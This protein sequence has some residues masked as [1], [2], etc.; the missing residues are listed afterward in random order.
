MFGPPAAAGPLSRTLADTSGHEVAAATTTNET[1][2]RGQ[3]TGVPHGLQLNQA[4]GQ[5]RPRWLISAPTTPA[6]RAEDTGSPADLLSSLH[7]DPRWD[8][9]SRAYE[10]TLGLALAADPAVLDTARAAVRAVHRHQQRRGTVDPS[11]AAAVLFPES[12]MPSDPL[13]ALE[14]LL[15]PATDVTLSRLMDM[16]ARGTGLTDWFA[17]D[18]PR[19]RDE[20]GNHRRD[21]RD[22]GLPLGDGPAHTAQK[23]LTRYRMLPGTRREDSA[24]FREVVLGWLLPTGRHSLT[25]IL[26]ASHAAGLGDAA[27]RAVV[28]G[29]AAH[30]YAWAERTLRPAGRPGAQDPAA[31]RPPHRALYATDAARIGAEA[32]GT[33]ML[34][35]G[36]AGAIRRGERILAADPDADPDGLLEREQALLERLR[37]HGGSAL[38]GLDES[39]LTALYLLGG[40]DAALLGGV[41]VVPAARAAL[42]A[43]LEGRGDFPVL[44][45]EVPEFRSLV[46]EARAL[47]AADRAARLATSAVLLA[48]VVARSADLLRTRADQH[49]AVALEALSLLPPVDTAVWWGSWLPGEAPA[50]QEAADALPGVVTVARLHPVRLSPSAA[51]RALADASR[52]GHHPVLYEVERS[53][54]RDISPY[55]A[56]PE[57]RR[58]AHA[59]P[60]EFDVTARVPRTDP[61]TGLRYTLVRLA[62]RPAVLPEAPA[63]RTAAPHY[64]EPDYWN[65]PWAGQRTVTSPSEIAAQEIRTAD[66]RLVGRASFTAADWSLRAPFYSGLRDTAGY[67]EWSR[68]PGGIRVARQRALPATGSGGTFFWTS[69]GGTD[70]FTVAGPD[71]LPSGATGDTVGRLLGT[72]PRDAGFTSVTVVV[73]EPVRGDGAPADPADT[74]RRVQGIADATGLDVFVNTGRV[75]V[76]PM[77]R[78]DGSPAAAV[79]L[80]ENADG[81][82][83]GWL[84]VSP[85]FRAAPPLPAPP[86]ERVAPAGPT[87]QAVLPGNPWSVSRWRIPGEPDSLRFGPL[88]ARRDWRTLSYQYEV[89]LARHIAARPQTRAVLVDA[90]SRLHARL[91]AQHGPHGADLALGLAAPGQPA[92]AGQAGPSPALARF[93]E[94][95]PTVGQ[96]M[97]AFSSAAYGPAPTS[98]RNSEPGRIG[99]PHPPH[100]R[101]HRQGAYRLAHDDRGFRYVGGT[102]GPA[103][104]LLQAYRATGADAQRMVAFRSAVLAW[105]VLTDNQSLAEV[106][107][108]SHLAG[109]GTDEE[110]VAL[111]RDGARLHLWARRSLAPD[112]PLPLPHHAA[113]DATTRFRSSY[114]LEIPG[115]IATALNAA[116]T[117]TKVPEKSEELT[118][119][120]E[121]ARK[122]LERFGE[123]GRR[124][125]T[126]LAPG[127]LTALFRYTGSD[128]KLFKTFVTAS[129]LG[130]AGVRWLMRH[131]V[132]TLALEDARADHYSRPELLLG[133][134]ELGDVISDLTDLLG[135]SENSDSDSEDLPDAGEGPDPEDLAELRRRTDRIADRISDALALHV[136]MATEALEML[137]PVAAPVWWGGWLP[138]PVDAPGPSPLLHDGTLFVT[139]FRSTTERLDL[140]LGFVRDDAELEE[141]RHP[142]LGHLP[143]STAPLVTPFSMWLTEEEVLYPPGRAHTVVARQVREDANISEPY[144][145]LTVAE[146]PPYPPRAYHNAEDVEEAAAGDGTASAPARP[147]APDPEPPVPRGTL[148]RTDDGGADLDG[149]RYD[150]RPVPAAPGRTAETALLAALGDREPL[151]SLLPEAEPGRSAAFRTWLAGAL[152]DERLTDEEVPPLD[153]SAMVPLSLLESA[154]HSLTGSQRTQGAL[155]GDVL[156]VADLAAGPAVRLRLLLADPSLGGADTEPPLSVLLAAAL[157]AL[158]VPAA[159]AQA[160]GTVTRLG[161]DAEDPAVLLVHDGDQWFAGTSVTAVTDSAAAAPAPGRHAAD[162]SQRIARAIDDAPPAVRRRLRE[163]ATAPAPDEAPAWIRGRI[164]YLEQAELFERRLGDHLADRPEINDQIAVMAAELFRRADAAGRWRELGSD[165]PTV[166]GVVG[167]DRDRIEAVVASGNLRERMGLLWV[168]ERTT[169]DLLGVSNLNPPQ[170]EAERADRPHH[171]DLDA[172]EALTALGTALSP[173]DR[174]RLTRLERAL[175]VPLAPEQVRPPLS[176]AE[177]ALMPDGVL[178]WIPGVSRYDIAMSTTLPTAAHATGGLV[179]AGTSGTTHRLLRNAAHMREQWGLDIDL[180]LVR[181]ALMAEMLPVRHHSLHEIMRASQMVLDDLRARGIAESP[182]LDYADNW[183]RYWRIA[184]LTEEELRAHV[185][186]DGLFPDEHARAEM[187]RP[188]GGPLPG[189]PGRAPD[190]DEA[191]WLDAHRHTMDDVL[192]L[193]TALGPAAVPDDAGDDRDTGGRLRRL[194]EDWFRDRGLVPSLDPDRNIRRILDDHPRHLPRNP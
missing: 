23:A 13:A 69:H 7:T 78:P 8:A 158:G 9:A 80:L 64:P 169:S 188:A 89:N 132:W 108:A 122:W 112:L 159:V 20:D 183:G 126:S 114:D 130:P 115:D 166:D 38:D 167:V 189:G 194:V 124:A 3:A 16:Y 59:T 131:R 79:H 179:R 84:R 174:D 180:G 37:R 18:R 28:L 137:P 42:T 50:S 76:T 175:R 25:E 33:W 172:Y 138:G 72:G 160:D 157:R 185:A 17:T 30:L 151:T 120:A 107:R 193:L 74:A 44:L 119:R 134:D 155:L 68:G 4:P 27:E 52:D 116:L 85:A 41:P 95:Q 26:R 55:A 139:R 56:N 127:H 49:T 97:Q 19:E 62:E 106:L 75:A 190:P 12:A 90:V 118:E 136:D 6:G 54:A 109:V 35:E 128:H 81:T 47:P 140:A 91:A 61:D 77:R 186:V 154:G 165:D 1:Y 152:D 147:T 187:D 100:P 24:A 39:H 144:A 164:R 170:I 34:P 43:A 51:L 70:G 86:F 45:M 145:V 149:T 21:H 182:D 146:L 5:P 14:G 71:G 105:S 66:G 53:S 92:A 93:L 156:P 171:A 133:D 10:R 102:V 176:A 113:Y 153:P 150:L 94:Q 22:R 2:D 121:A 103:L 48:D 67:T 15:D 110:R 65:N 192:D 40:P 162:R 191:A 57:E 123:A 168:G 111:T 60:A 104:W 143:R 46:G 178:P 83:N 177:R 184:P 29:D 129:R 135:T 88:Y 142:V 173:A 82:P 96:L 63:Q 161:P 163:L 101:G 141:D 73:C 32:T 125:V 181:L 148:R 87:G 31:L 11:R 117:G 36:L 99:S 98:L 58:A